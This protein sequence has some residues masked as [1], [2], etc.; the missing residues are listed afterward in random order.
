MLLEGLKVVEM[1]TWVAGPGCAGLM[2]DWGADVV[3]VESAEGDATRRFFPDTPESPGN[4]IFSMENRDKRGVVLDIARPDGRAALVDILR[5][6]DVFVTN[7][8]PGSLARARLDHASLRDELPRLVYATVTGYGLEGAEADAP[9]FDL[10]GFW[11]RSGVAASTIPPDQ[12]PFVCR[13]G[14]GDH[15]T[16]LAMLGGVL[17][18]L[19]ERDLTGRGRLVEA[20]LLRAGYYAL[21]WDA[22]QHLRFGAAATARPRSERPSAL[23]GFFRAADGGWFCLVPRGPACFGKLAAAIDRPE[24]LEEARFTPPIADLAVVRE[25]RARL[26]EAF[27]GF[28]LAEIGRRLTRADLIWA[29]M[30]TLA[31]VEAD[32]QARAAGCFVTTRDRFGGA[33]GAPA[34]PVRF[35]GTPPRVHAAAPAL[36][37]HTREVLRAAGY[38]RARIA[39]LLRA[40]AA[41]QAPG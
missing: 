23:S 15:V 33:F 24:L 19:R 10:T 8:R 32:P 22:S 16:A 14:F 34:S 18:A 12:E 3:K 29:P 11:T 20:S 27:A 30:A 4:P 41:F 36:G 35:P 1:A 26:D 37:E 31:D 5:T 6:A 7:S 2:A 13:P 9:A 40:G 39:D 17:A 25:L 38:S 21:S 28:T